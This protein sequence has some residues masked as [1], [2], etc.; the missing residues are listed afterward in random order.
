MM[1]RRAAMSAAGKR[2]QRRRLRVMYYRFAYLKRPL[3]T[4]LAGLVEK[5]CCSAHRRVRCGAQVSRG[6][7]GQYKEGGSV[8]E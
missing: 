4:Q 1:G 2:L 3:A 5:R 8:H 7:G 6:M